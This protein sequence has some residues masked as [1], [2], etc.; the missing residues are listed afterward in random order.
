MRDFFL[1]FVSVS[2][3]ISCRSNVI[4]IMCYCRTLLLTTSFSVGLVAYL[5]VLCNCVTWQIIFV[6]SNTY[7]LS[8][9]PPVLAV[10]TCRHQPICSLYT[11]IKLYSGEATVFWVRRTRC[12]QPGEPYSR[13][14]CGLC[15]GN[16]RIAS[17]HEQTIN[18]I[19]RTLNAIIHG[20]HMMTLCGGTRA[21]HMRCTIIKTCVSVCVV[22]Q[23]WWCNSGTKHFVVCISLVLFFRLHFLFQKQSNRTF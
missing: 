10:Y 23:S 13:S 6:R 4:S 5:W 22:V 16:A 2:L 15:V 14:D 8:V 9:G 1:C 7:N 21:A 12:T 19:R 18:I 11:C 3:W 20:M 17:M